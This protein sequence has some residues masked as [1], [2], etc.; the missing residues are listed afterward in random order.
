MRSEYWFVIV[1]MLALDIGEQYTLGYGF[2]GRK[3][4]VSD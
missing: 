2:G 4:T 1:N 3:L